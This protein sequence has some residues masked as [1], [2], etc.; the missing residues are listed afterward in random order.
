MDG[1]DGFEVA[2]GSF[3]VENSSVAREELESQ[4]KKRHLSVAGLDDAQGIDKNPVTFPRIG[5]YQSWMGNMPE[6]WVRYFL[7]DFEIPFQTLRNENFTSRG[8][9]PV[10]LR[11]DYDVIVFADEDPTAIKQGRS[12]RSRQPLP[13]EYRRGIGEAGIAALKAFVSDGGILVALGNACKL[14]LNELGVPAR[15][16]VERVDRDTFFCP[17]S[18]LRLDVDNL[19]PIGYGMPAE[20]AAV[21]SRSVVMDTSIPGGGWDRRVVASFPDKDLLLS[22]WLLG[23][24]VIARKAAVVDLSY[25]EGRVVLIGIRSQNRAQSH[26]TYKFLL[27]AF[28]Y[29]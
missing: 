7:D 14:V 16:A 24:Q 25:G 22:G 5:L 6:G 23:E 29:P 2:A 10:R 12:A 21:F 20:A 27:N 28:L 15:N 11:S 1:R 9:G 13:P 17:A 4:S 8:D 19:S 26:G 3:L 18:L